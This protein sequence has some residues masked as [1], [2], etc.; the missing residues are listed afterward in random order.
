MDIA[1]LEAKRENIL[2][3][4]PSLK[5][6]LRTT[7]NKCYLTC[8]YKKCHCHKGKKHGPF[9]YLTATIS[10]K[11]KGYFVPKKIIKEV[12]T[13]VS[14]YNQLWKYICELCEINRKI[15]WIKKKLC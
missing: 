4:V 14:N 2:K 15:L 7:I 3:K 1:K 10:G 9:I 11:T 6:I 5:K 13:G 12:K 8:G